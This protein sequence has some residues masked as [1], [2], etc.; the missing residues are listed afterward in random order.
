MC[1]EVLGKLR[2]QKLKFLVFRQGN[3]EKML[4]Q[5]EV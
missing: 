2:Q 4:K 5:K 3:E 1:G